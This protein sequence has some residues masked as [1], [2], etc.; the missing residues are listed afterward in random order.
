M[1]EKLIPT[2]AQEIT[3]SREHAEALRHA[4]QIACGYYSTTFE[5]S[6]EKESPGVD[7]YKRRN[8]IADA[9]LALFSALYGPYGDGKAE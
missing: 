2:S 8:A 7:E 1:N 4:A 6:P 5:I 3:I 9:S